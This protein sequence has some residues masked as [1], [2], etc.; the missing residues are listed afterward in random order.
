MD[1]NITPGEYIKLIRRRKKLSLVQVAET[2]GV[3]IATISRIEADKAALFG[4]VCAVADA[5]GIAIS[6]LAIMSKKKGSA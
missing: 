2:S 4:N 5:L 3:S 1:K 6:E